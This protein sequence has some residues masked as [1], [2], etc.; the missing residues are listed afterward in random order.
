MIKSAFTKIADFFKFIYARLFKINDSPQKV[1]IGFGLGVFTGILPGAGPLAA[2]FLAFIFRVNRAAALL[3]SVITN[4]WLSFVTFV[5]A[6]KAG[7]TI[8]N[9]SWEKLQKDWA[10]ATDNWHWQ[11]LFSVSI[12]KIILPVMAGYII[13]SLCLGIISYVTALIIIKKRKRR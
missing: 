9:I 11:D 8:F 2:L 12:L 5:L 10:V 13:I 6:I 3:G 7:S 4:T 1:A